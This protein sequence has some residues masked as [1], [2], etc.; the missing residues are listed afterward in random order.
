M[1][2]S[3]HEVQELSLFVRAETPAATSLVY[4]TSSYSIQMQVGQFQIQKRT[5]FCHIDA[6]S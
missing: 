6:S 4:R 3:L 2:D 1:K 5:G